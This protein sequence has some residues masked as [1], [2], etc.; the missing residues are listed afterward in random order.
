MDGVPEF[1]TKS[2][3]VRPYDFAF[4]FNAVILLAGGYSYRYDVAFRQ[5]QIGFNKGTFV[6]Q[7]FDL[8]LVDAVSSRKERRLGAKFSRIF[9]FIFH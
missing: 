3:L 7:V 5:K 9:S 2:I 8:T 6:A 4:S 1:H